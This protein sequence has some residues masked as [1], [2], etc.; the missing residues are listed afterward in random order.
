MS[1]LVTYALDGAIATI[2]M[3]EGLAGLNIAAHAAT[4]LR[5]R[6]GALSAIRAAIE[7]ELT[8]EGLTGAKS[9]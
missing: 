7:S 1:E 8:I 6:A 2:T 4:K 5:A 3:A 9:N